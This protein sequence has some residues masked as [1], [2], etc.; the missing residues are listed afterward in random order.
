MRIRVGTFISVCRPGATDTQVR[1]AVCALRRVCVCMC[2]CARARCTRTVTSLGY[3]DVPGPEWSAFRKSRTLAGP[4]SGRRQAPLFSPRASSLALSRVSP[5]RLLSPCERTSGEAVHCITPLDRRA[6][7]KYRIS[8][9]PS[10][11]GKKKKDDETKRRDVVSRY[12][13][14]NRIELSIQTPRRAR[15]GV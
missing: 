1:S 7:T 3:L 11:C 5:L 10:E 14:R 6:I 2:V 8:G 9:G 15:S 13:E 12:T 4:D